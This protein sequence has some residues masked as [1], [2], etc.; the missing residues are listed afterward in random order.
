MKKLLTASIILFVIIILAVTGFF[1]YKFY[2]QQEAQKQDNTKNQQQE[3]IKLDVE[4]DLLD[5]WTKY[6]NGEFSFVM[7]FPDSWNNY[8][9]E[10][11]KWKGWLIDGSE[12]SGDYSG[13]ELVFINP[14]YEVRKSEGEGLA[15]FKD[16]WQNIPIMAISKD[17]WNL[18]IQEKIAVS[19]APVGPGKIG[20]NSKFVF[21]LPPRW[22]GFSCTLG[23]EEAQQIVKTFKAY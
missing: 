15:P 8:T 12:E 11:Q 19:A 23:V 17:V 1:V 4:L 20:E 7:G 18:I 13:D 21:A 9:V 5:G 22:A 3:Q 14:R 6:E 16:C 10:R 2:F